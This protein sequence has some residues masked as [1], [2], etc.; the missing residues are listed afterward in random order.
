MKKVVIVET[1]PRAKSNSSALAEEFARGAADAGNE[2][3]VASLRELEYGWCKGC[4][5]CI[6][7]K[8]GHCVQRDDLDELAQRIREADVLA[9]ATPIYFYTMSGQMKAVLDR[10]TPL[11][12]VGT[13]FSDVYLIAMGA[14]SDESAFEGAVHDLKLWTDC[15][16]GARI[17]GTLLAGGL[18]AQGAAAR[19]TELL[20]K[21]YAMGHAA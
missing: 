10:M 2:V 13:R 9:L 14:E 8:S 20:A 6:K 4:L 18:Q 19:N 11:L 15:Y 21:A 16:E 3:E 12:P 5:A 1:S 7:T 17:A